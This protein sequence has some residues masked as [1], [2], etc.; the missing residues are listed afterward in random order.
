MTEHY[1]EQVRDFVARQVRPNVDRWEREG[2]Y[3]LELH[4]LAGR[5]GL[6][7]LGHAPDTLPAD[8]PALG[9]LVEELT[10]S[11]AQGI[12]MGLAS[13][14]VSLGAVQGGDARL[15]AEVIPAVLSGEQRIVL[16]L[17]EPQ[18][19]S[20]LR[21]LQCR[22][23]PDG[24]LYRL[25]GEKAFIC[26]GGRAELLLVGAVIEGALGLFLVNGF[27]P[28][29]SHERLDCLG[30]RCLPLASL[31][32]E[33]APARL[34]LAGRQA[35]RLLQQ[36][37]LQERLNLAIMAVTSAELAQGEAVAY[38]RQ[39]R[40]GG[41]PLL[42]KSV[43]RQRLAELHAALSVSRLYVDQAVRWQASGQLTAAQAAIAKNVA[44]D[45]LEQVA[46]AAVQ[47]HGAHGCVEPALVERIYR[48][49][50]LLA[51]GGGARE[52]ML[53]IIGRTL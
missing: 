22:A 20:D 48:D 17:T 39:R 9:V 33:G 16:A 25:S 46:R 7:A 28:G 51:I 35:S 11:G 3:P 27:A 38:C 42:E 40:V 36:C 52:V 18:A 26:N 37:L 12:T 44:V 21:A 13:H 30:W 32:F 47:V 4:T 10:R 14:F 19:G 29:L 43:I 34:L 6:L 1:R 49:A 24:G 41:T 31:R 53:E 5:A 50:R 2:S 45:T 8:V 23:E 15:A